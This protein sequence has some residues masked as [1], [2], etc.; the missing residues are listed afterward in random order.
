MASEHL[1]IFTRYPEVGQVKTRLIPALGAT[2]ATELHRQ[3]VRHTLNQV[4]ALR[5]RRLQ[6]LQVTVCFAGEVD[7]ARVEAWIGAEFSAQPQAAGDLGDRLTQGFETAFAAGASQVLAI[8]T[9]CP[10]L[11][12]A[13][14]EQ[15]LVALADHDVV[16]GPAVDGGYYL[17]G[18]R[19]SETARR[20]SQQPQLFTNITWGTGVVLEQ[21]LAAIKSQ[22]L[23]Y[24]LLTTLADV[25]RP[26]DLPV[27]TAI[28][29]NS[30][31][32]RAADYP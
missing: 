21:T 11:N 17:I 16:L 2:A 10:G 3:M 8:G 22:H 9:D 27:W 25:D 29:Q 7:V 24:R 18:L 15:A 19:W 13:V 31:Q 20:V 26:E 12:A 32:A 5:D 4:K 1:L 14:M 28:A 6:P 23:S 30:G